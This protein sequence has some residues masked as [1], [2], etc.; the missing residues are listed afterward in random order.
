MPRA[1]R[2]KIAVFEYKLL[3]TPEQP[4]RTF[5]SRNSPN[6]L[7]KKELSH[8][9]YSRNIKIHGGK[10]EIA[11]AVNANSTQTAGLHISP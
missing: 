3:D 6:L 10:K 1:F 8:I 4:R 2:I 5:L 7:F 9:K 11:Y